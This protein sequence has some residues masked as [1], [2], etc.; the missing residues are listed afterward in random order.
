MGRSFGLFAPYFL[1]NI[2]F[3][4]NPQV[5]FFICGFPAW[6]PKISK[7]LPSKSMDPQLSNA[8]SNVLIALF[9][10]DPNT[11]KHKALYA[12]LIKF[13]KPRKIHLFY[14]RISSH[15]VKGIGLNYE[16]PQETFLFYVGAVKMK[17]MIR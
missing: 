4:V 11:F 2:H 13:G 12:S 1:K 7:F 3:S 6:Y 10:M 15:E 9:G 17:N 16:N 5:T 8:F 14:S